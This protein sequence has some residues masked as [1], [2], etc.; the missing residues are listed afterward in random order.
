MPTQIER[1]GT[2]IQIRSHIA[3]NGPRISFP[4]S[5]KGQF[6]ASL[7]AVNLPG[8]REIAV[9]VFDRVEDET[10]SPVGVFVT[11]GDAELFRTAKGAGFSKHVQGISVDGFT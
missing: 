1:K 5:Q 4:N 8:Q 2:D 11:E 3:G 6:I 10:S 7:N 9:G